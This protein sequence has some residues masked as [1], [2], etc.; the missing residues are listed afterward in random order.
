[1]LSTIPSRWPRVFTSI[2]FGALLIATLTV[3]N[4]LQSTYGPSIAAGDSLERSEAILEKLEE[5]FS[6]EKLDEA[7]RLAK[8][9]GQQIEP[10]KSSIT[11]RGLTGDLD[12]PDGSF[13]IILGLGALFV[14][15][16]VGEVATSIFSEAFTSKSG[17]QKEA[18]RIAVVAKSSSPILAE[19]LGRH[20]NFQDI[21]AGT[22]AIVCSNFLWLVPTISNNRLW[23]LGLLGLLIT[24]F[25]SVFGSL[26]ERRHGRTLD[27]ALQEQA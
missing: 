14:L 27:Y 15:F 10:M 3:S 24:F 21:I 5:E 17:S 4:D 7:R 16:T 19:E 20:R 8:L 12:V 1:M 2:G 13:G 6:E 26:F 11:Y 25:V 22:Q 18:W 23:A 9:A